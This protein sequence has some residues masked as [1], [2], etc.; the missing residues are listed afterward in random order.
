A[1]QFACWL[2]VDEH[3]NV[4]THALPVGVRDVHADVARDGVHMDGAVGRGGDGG[5]D[6]DRILEGGLREDGARRHAFVNEGGGAAAGLI[7]D[8][9]ALAVGGRDGGAAG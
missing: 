9:G 1:E 4:R 6:D 5:G 2:E 3:G 8:L 7:G